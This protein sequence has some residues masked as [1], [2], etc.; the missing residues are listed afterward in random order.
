LGAD[1]F[2]EEHAGRRIYVLGDVEEPGAYT[3]QKPISVIEA[4]AMAGSYLPT[5]TVR[6]VAVVRKRGDKMVGTVLDLE[7]A[8]RLKEAGEFFY[9]QPDDIVYVPRRRISRWA[10]IA[11]DISD[12]LFFRGWGASVSYEIQDGAED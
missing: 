1:L 11:R 4:I 3:I 2:L 7:G 10:D 5:S 6:R 9:L 8:L 12:I